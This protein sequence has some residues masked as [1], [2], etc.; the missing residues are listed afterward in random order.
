MKRYAGIIILS[1]VFAL[2]VAGCAGR[3]TAD[4]VGN[5]NADL[6]IYTTFYPLHYFTQRIAGDKASAESLVPAGVEPHEYEP[7]MK[8]M[9]G[10]YDGDVF[11]FLGESM[12][13]WA[14]KLQGNLG[15]KGISVLEAGEGIIAENDPHV[16]LDP[17]LAREISQKIF[18]ALAK[19]DEQN[20][21]YYKQNYLALENQLEGLH[22]DYKSALSQSPRKDVVTSHAIFGYL[23]RRYGLNQWAVAGLSPQEEPSLK[24]LMELTEIVKEL[25]IKYIFTET[26]G[27]GKLSDSLAREAGISTLVFNPLESLTQKELDDGQDYF[28]VMRQNLEVLK[29]ALAQ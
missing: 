26:L 10:I 25:G 23:A 1:L 21:D 16:W 9:G 18:A 19:A 27:S 20:A 6:K 13:P 3:G 15:E 29:T 7:S 4:R 28:S 14:K 22:E 8:Q 2:V 17:L 12:E 5:G 24:K 11:I